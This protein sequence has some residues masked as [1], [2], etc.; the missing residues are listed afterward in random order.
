MSTDLENLIDNG[1]FELNLNG[2]ETTGSTELSSTEKHSGTKS[3]KITN[4]GSI[5][6]YE[7][8]TYQ[9]DAWTFEMYLL[10]ESF[11]GPGGLRLQRKI[12]GTFSDAM[13]TEITQTPG[14]GWIKHSITYTVPAGVTHIRALAAFAGTGVVYV[15]SIAMYNPILSINDPVYEG[16]RRHA[17]YHTA[18][19][20]ALKAIKT[21]M[22]TIPPSAYDEGDQ[23]IAGVKTF[24][25][26]PIV[27]DPTA[28]GG[29]TTKK[30]ADD[31]ITPKQNT[32]AAGTNTQYRRG[33]GTWQTLGKSSVGLSNVANTSDLNKPISTALQTALNAKA[34]LSTTLTLS[35][36]Q[37]ITGTKS[38]SAGPKLPGP[39][40]IGYVWTASG[41]DGAGQWADPNAVG[42]EDITPET[43]PTTLPPTIGATSTTAA[44][45]NH[46]HTKASIGLGSVDNTSD[47]NKPISNATQTALNDKVSTSRSISTTSPL[48]GGGDLTANRT[49]GVATEGFNLGHLTDGAKYQ[50]IQFYQTLTTREVG[51]GQIPEGFVFPVAM[52]LLSVRYRIGTPDGSGLTIVELRR[53]GVAIA[54]SSGTASTDPTQITGVMEF[55]A[56]D[57]LTVYT[58]Q[59]GTNPGQ[60]LKAEI[61]AVL[62]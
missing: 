53:N 28:T 26:S 27:P 46:S 5:F 15:D 59:V 47:V 39:T 48:T 57:I 42:Y 22:D 35:G 38:F 4:A 56:G 11:T 31:L 12:G 13:P 41:T 60:R 49:I 43:K 32:I 21:F 16:D 62:I 30:Y 17:E 51:A 8:P 44:A 14:Q 45:G 50:S 20:Q 1:Q 7:F 52:N 33:D 2:W 18:V 24:D 36:D 37:A 9:G 25:D 61:L 23:A 3:L 34:D 19:H 29:A 55:L 40:T 10:N 6:G 58:T 54:G